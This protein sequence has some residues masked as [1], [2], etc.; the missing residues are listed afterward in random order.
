M[1]VLY[2]YT[3]HKYETSCMNHISM[4]EHNNTLEDKPYVRELQL[5]DLYGTYIFFHS[6]LHKFLKRFDDYAE[7]EDDAK[8]MHESE[9]GIDRLDAEEEEGERGGLSREE[10]AERESE[11]SGDEE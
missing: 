7:M 6:I 2:E 9:E 4:K 8:E 10:E 11:R 5:V 1:L 3:L